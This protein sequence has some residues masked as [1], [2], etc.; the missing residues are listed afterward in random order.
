MGNLQL[1]SV[2]WDLDRVLDKREDAMTMNHYDPDT[3]LGMDEITTTI[4]E[5]TQPTPCCECDGSSTPSGLDIG[6][7]FSMPIVAIAILHRVMNPLK[8]E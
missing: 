8:G 4:G 5:P 3:D 7:A 2:R 1:V 6:L